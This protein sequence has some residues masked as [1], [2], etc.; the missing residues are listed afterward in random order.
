MEQNR[1]QLLYDE[2]VQQYLNIT[3][4]L[5]HENFDVNNTRVLI[6]DTLK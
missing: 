3:G 5:Q 2:K 1:F 4:Y 6:R